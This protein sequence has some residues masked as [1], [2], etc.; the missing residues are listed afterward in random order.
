VTVDSPAA[1]QQLQALN[2]ALTASG[3]SPQGI[4]ELD[5]I[6]SVT[7]DYNPSAYTTQAYQLEALAQQTAPQSAAATVVNT[8]P[9]ANNA[10][11]PAAKAAAA[12]GT[13]ATG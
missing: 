8:Q 2:L 3:L 12:G 11:A 6:A 7:Q 4:Q 13:P 1:Q 9:T 10:N 5:Q